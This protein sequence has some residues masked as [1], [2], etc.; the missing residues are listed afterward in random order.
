MGQFALDRDGEVAWMEPV[1]ALAALADEPYTLLMHGGGE[2]EQGR[3]SYL[4]A[5]PEFV[6]EG[7]GR[8]AAEAAA[9]AVGGTETTRPSQ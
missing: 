8:D 6:V 2:G 9:A 5:F 3:L 4:C 7:D 1:A